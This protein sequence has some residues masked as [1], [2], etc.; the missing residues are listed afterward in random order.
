VG[1]TL[2]SNDLLHVKASLA[3]VSESGLKTGEARRRVV[4]V[5]PSRRLHLSQVE[6]GWV[7]ATGCVRLCYPC[8]AIFILLGPRGIVVI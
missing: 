8:F 7:D 6:D 5:A 3:S 2:R 1:H 4:H